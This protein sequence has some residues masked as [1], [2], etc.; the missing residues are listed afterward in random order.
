MLV[1]LMCNTVYDKTNC[2]YF[3]WC[4]YS[5][6]SFRF[7][8][9][10]FALLPGECAEKFRKF[11]CKRYFSQ[12][13]TLAHCF[14]IL[15]VFNKHAKLGRQIWKKFGKM[16]CFFKKKNIGYDCTC[17]FYIVITT[18]KCCVQMLALFRMGEPYYKGLKN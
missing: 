1:Y 5:S 16:R 2:S 17:S 8:S 3:P 9:S 15:I 7:V 13:F 14:S 18:T 4:S 12:L 11:S 10:H 6:L